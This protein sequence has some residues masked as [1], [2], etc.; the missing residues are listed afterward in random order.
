M[1]Q[2]PR[3]VPSVYAHAS[4]RLSR[5]RMFVQGHVRGHMH[6]HWLEL[7]PR[8]SGGGIA[9]AARARIRPRA[10]ALPTL[11]VSRWSPRALHVSR[12]VAAAAMWRLVGW[13]ERKEACIVCVCVG[14]GKCEGRSVLAASGGAISEGCRR[15]VGA[16]I[17]RRSRPHV[18][19]EF[20]GIRGMPGRTAGSL[21]WFS[22]RFPKGSFVVNSGGSHC[23]RFTGS[24]NGGSWARIARESRRGMMPLSSFSEI[25][26]K[27]RET[28]SVGGR[29]ALS[30]SFPNCLK[31]MCG[32]ASARRSGCCQ[33]RCW[34]KKGAAHG[35]CGLCSGDSSKCDGVEPASG[36]IGDGYCHRL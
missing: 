5:S 29:F 19:A 8:R 18:Q 10:R 4:P 27:T 11:A 7:L 32:K 36:G 31:H 6:A 23:L 9:P 33:H 30:R 15:D 22:T 34:A 2:T 35:S 16:R 14:G 17:D 21:S 12:L 26:G 3:D 25:L 20:G 24:S 28:S 1:E 13:R